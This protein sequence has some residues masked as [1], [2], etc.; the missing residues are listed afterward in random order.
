[1]ITLLIVNGPNLDRLGQRTPDIY[2]S[3]TLEQLGSKVDHK[4][5]ELEVNA[6]SYQSNFEGEL[7][8]FIN[9]NAPNA[10]GI[11]INPAGLTSVGYSL[12]DAC[13]DS[14]LPFVEVHISNIYGREEWRA[15]SIFS[16]SSNASVSGMQWIGYIAAIDYLT[17]L[18][19]GEV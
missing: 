14:S 10:H 4:A 19:K 8:N 13:I 6:L 15:R 12:L 9:Q 2:G 5:K 17:A 11:I 18:I 16:Q 1:M 7:V 3:V